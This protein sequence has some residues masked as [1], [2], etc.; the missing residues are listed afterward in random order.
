MSIDYWQQRV[1]MTS[2]SKWSLDYKRQLSIR[3]LYYYC[4]FNSKNRLKEKY[5]KDD[6]NVKKDAYVETAII[7]IHC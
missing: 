5:L 7:F 6:K 3:R 2:S 1:Q 4:Y